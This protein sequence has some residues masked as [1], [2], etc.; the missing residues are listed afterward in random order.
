[1]WD[2]LDEHGLLQLSMQQLHDG[3]G[4]GDGGESVP[5][6]ITGKRKSVDD[7]SA[8]SLKVTSATKSSTKNHSLAQALRN[9]VS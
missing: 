8:V 4:S 7:Y 5:F 2:M 1:M 3:I 6:A 9:M